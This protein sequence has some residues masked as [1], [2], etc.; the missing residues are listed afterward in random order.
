[1]HKFMLMMLLSVANCSAM[2][3]WIEIDHSAIQTSYADPATMNI[4]GS[5]VIL[6]L[7]SNYKTPHKYSGKPFFSIQSQNEYDCNNAQFR[8]LEYS[9]HSGEMG[10]GEVIYRN[11]NA[12]KWRQTAKGSADETFWKAACS[13]TT[14][15][16]KVGESKIMFVYANPFSIRKNFSLLKTTAQVSMWELFDLK[17][18]K[19]RD[20]GLKY[21]SVMHRA[22]Y[23]CKENQYRTLAVS[24][25]A[26]NMAKGDLIFADN[27]PQKWDAV[28]AGSA[29]EVFWKM[30]CN[31]L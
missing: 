8:M 17:T 15:W 31:K 3:E 2:A 27:H 24:Y 20:G 7:L 6:P 10:G 21:L 28:K 14:G 9:L 22:E 19:E 30:A 1:M 11:T 18:A 23:D 5:K 12:D 16:V 13:P 26:E 4:A 29:D 25:H